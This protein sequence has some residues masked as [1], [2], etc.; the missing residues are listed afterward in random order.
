[1]DGDVPNLGKYA[2]CRRVARTIYMGS[3]PTTTAAHLGL[4]DRRIKLGCVLPG[5]SPAVFG[6]ALRR[7]AGTATYLYQDGPRYWYSTQPTVTKLAEDRAEQLKRATDKVVHELE[8]RIRED[9]TEDR[10]EKT[11][12]KG[13]FSR[14]HPLP[15]GSQDVPDDLDARLVVLGIDHPYSKEQ[16]NAAETM[17]KIILETRGTSPRTNR[18]TLVFLAADKTRLQELDEAARRYLAWKS[19]LAETNELNLSPHQVTQAQTQYDAAE[20]TVMARLPETYQWLLIPVQS[21]PQASTAW[22]AQRLTGQEGL[23]VRASRKLRPDHLFTGLA[24]TMLRLEMDKVPLWRGEHVSVKQL[25]EDFARYLYLPRLKE[26]AVLL[27]AIREGVALLTWE[28]DTFAFADSYDESVGRYRGL[29]AGQQVI[30]VDAETPSLL[31]KSEVAKRQFEAENSKSST[32]SASTQP[33]SGTKDETKGK[34]RVAGDLQS[35]TPVPAAPK[36]F[37]GTVVLDSTRVGRDASRI[38]DEVIV[39]L[40][41]LMGANVK[42]SLEIDAEVPDGVPENVVRT[43]TENSRTL[44]FS[45][46]GFE[47]D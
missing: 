37:H 29:R 45:S 11:S 14:I 20:S 25:V 12:K 39:H 41:G 10:R 28:T 47:T 4:E 30:L 1:L 42:V 17:A 22:Q 33:S 13:D 36:R 15:H 5:E 31:V 21:S 34:F 44:K 6:D 9:L 19:I 7:L 18:N 24:G 38:A 3:A 46:Q 8:R 16:G 26:S 32:D 35:P 27:G 43:V 23:A 2:A 40:A